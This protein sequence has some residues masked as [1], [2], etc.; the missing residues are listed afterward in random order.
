MVGDSSCRP[1]RAWSLLLATSDDEGVGG[2]GEVGVSTDN[3]DGAGEEADEDEDKDGE[4]MMEV[5]EEVLKEEWIARGFD[6]EAFDSLVLLEMWASE[7]AEVRFA[8]GVPLLC[9]G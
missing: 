9:F 4:E 8:H 7:E 6:P 3:G 5:E 2:V 1:R